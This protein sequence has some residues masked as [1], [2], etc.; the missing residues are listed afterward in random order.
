[1]TTRGLE[2]KDFAQVA[3]FVDEAVKLTIEIKKQVSGTKIKDFKEAVGEK[4]DAFP[5]IADLKKRIVDFSATFPV[6][7]FDAKTMKY[8]R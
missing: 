4:G 1:M 8:S 6:I 3:K 7:G 5:Q 2:K